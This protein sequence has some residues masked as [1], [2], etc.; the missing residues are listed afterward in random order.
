MLDVEQEIVEAYFESNG[1]L[2]RQ[3]GK[4]DDSE[5]KKK[6][7]PL[8]TIAVFNP[9]IQTSDSQ[10]SFR[11]FTGDLR[12]V[13]SAL[14]SR[15]GWENSSFSNSIL[16]SDARLLKF[17]KKEVTQERISLGYN[18]GPEL[19]GELDGELSLPFGCSGLP[20]NGQTQGV[21]H[22]SRDMGVGGV[23]S[24][25]SMLENL[26]RQSLPTLKYSNNGVFQMLKLLKVYQLAREPQLDMFSN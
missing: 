22:L 26:L 10:L 25:S 4:P 17:F 20:R 16:S 8:P 1:F 12:G 19:P 21:V 5:N 2:V 23:L 24:L 13:R 14:V 9:A 7:L 15:L 18:P 11:L 3:A 6:T